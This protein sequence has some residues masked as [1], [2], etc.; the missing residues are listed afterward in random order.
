MNLPSQKNIKSSGF[1]GLLLKSAATFF[2]VFL[3]NYFAPGI[4]HSQNVN[5]LDTNFIPF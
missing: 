2:T 3:I 1:Q 4:V 5:N